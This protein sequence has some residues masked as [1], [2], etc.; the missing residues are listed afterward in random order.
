[1]ELRQLTTEDERQVFARCL[2]QARATRG[3]RFADTARSR[4]GK[5]HLA[6]GDLYALFES[7]GDPAEKMKAGFT[8]H[9]LATLPQSFP[10][11][12]LS[13]LAPRS[14]L[15]GGEFWSLSTGAGK[16]V[17]RAAGA[18]VGILQ[19]Q[20]LLIYPIA[21]PVDLTP[22]YTQMRFVK[23]CDP[24]VWPFV[25]TLE[26]KEIVVQPMILEGEPLREWVRSAFELIFK[27]R[28]D[29]YLLR[30]ESESP[31]ERSVD[32]RSSAQDGTATGKTT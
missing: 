22:P 4:L 27:P 12:D 13:H 11:P 23:A 21:S 15:E 30:F 1:M 19:A 17:R 9:D 20:V 6:F 7:D 32:G 14:V 3:I 18:M 24:V 31:A 29:R 10:K 8:M 2:A 25:E 26:G 16:V 28:D 5:C